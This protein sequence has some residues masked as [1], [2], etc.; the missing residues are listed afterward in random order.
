MTSSYLRRWIVAVAMIAFACSPGD[1]PRLSESAR[2]SLERSEAQ[3]GAWLQQARTTNAADEAVLAAG[4]L[5]RLRLGLGSPF[6]LAE[7]ALLDP[8][9]SPESQRTLAWAILQRTLDGD[10]YS[11]DSQA[12]DRI[13]R[14]PAHGPG[15]G[16]RHRDLIRDAIA[17][18]RDARAGELAVRLAYQLA[19]AE[20]TV[21]S[22][23][24]KATAQVAAL[25]RDR[26]LARNDVIEL[27][28]EAERSDTDALL[29]LRTWR[30]E[31]RFAVEQPSMLAIGSN[32]EREAMELAP[33][34]GESV[35]RI[36]AEPVD[37]VAKNGVAEPS[38]I[39]PPAARRLLAITDSMETPPLAP[40][41][42]AARM[43]R[44]DLLEQPWVTP[45]HKAARVEFISNTTSEERFVARYTLLERAGPHDAAPAMAALSAAVG[46]R[47]LAQERV[48][49]PGFGGPSAREL[50]ER[51]GLAAVTFAESVPA[52]WRPYYRRMLDQSIADLVLVLPS[53]DLKGLRVHFAPSTGAGHTLAMH[54]PARRRLVL[55]PATTAGT[56]AH[57]V[58]H[59]L[60]W[61]VALRRYRVRG[62][63][64]SDRATRRG[65]RLA[66]EMSE[67]A[68]GLLEPPIAGAKTAHARRPAEV[69][70]RSIDWFVA[71]ALAEQG[72]SNGY[73]SSV[74]DGV[75]TGYGTVRPPDITGSAGDA[76]INILDEVAPVYPATR[77]WFLRS[78]G[79]R[80]SLTP[81]DL[82][83]QVLEVEAPEPD[84]ALLKPPVRL[85]GAHAA[86][87]R[88]QAIG[89]A[90]DEAFAAI[91]EWVCRA[92]ASAHDRQLE[93]ARRQLVSAAAA[94]RAR[95]LALQQARHLTGKPGADWLRRILFG[96]PWP[97]VEIDSTTQLM[98]GALAA[99]TRTVS[100]A[101]EP[102]HERG[103]DLTPVG[104]DCVAATFGLAAR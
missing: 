66:M 45:A 82:V 48:W 84:P 39:S 62:D 17:Q 2:G 59:D 81:F 55:P 76:L 50:E 83:R 65:D 99:E 38:L 53:L 60:D 49:F 11:V 41:T 104:Q 15:S 90:R 33:R 102:L 21:Q 8:R 22:S 43:Y 89:Q 57:E 7:Y 101:T 92:P 80:R 47:A 23:A 79:S 74:Q 34:L 58:A 86:A 75:L 54:E 94:A 1:T 10:A 96:A 12:L 25:L 72:R 32:A 9:L 69:F 67:L 6:R 77:E 20:G 78:Y 28:R 31:R 42:I 46:M 100:Q 70:A 19:A 18:S 71:V 13:S 56:I 93:S 29:L 98:L 27:L 30:A 73:L 35:R 68:N 36:A 40:I 44:Q 88:V 37:E 91:D 14:S 61:Q 63:Y 16:V 64:A 24:P 85:D 95:G 97:L 4:Y 87:L 52:A 5:E 51:H 26:A 103:F 3:A